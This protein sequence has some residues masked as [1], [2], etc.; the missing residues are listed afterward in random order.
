MKRTSF[1]AM[2]CSVARTL[3]I[4]GDAWTLL[5]VRDALFAPLRFDDL[6][7]SLGIPRTTLTNRLASL[8]EHDV[9]ERRDYQAAP[10]RQEY[11][12][13][14]KGRA[15]HPV[16]V[17]MLQW[18]DEWSS[19]EQPPVTLIDADTGDDIEPVYIDRR[20]GAELHDLAITRRHNT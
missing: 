18:G 6:Q 17:S 5:I 10:V 1:D 8:V 20:T 13:T 2:N 16:I 14:A 7:R 12:I 4:V 11:V 9:L 15:L 19:L 3:D